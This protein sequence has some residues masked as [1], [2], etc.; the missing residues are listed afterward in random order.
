MHR[1]AVDRYCRLASR[2]A[3]SSVKM[4][5]QM[6]GK[7]TEGPDRAELTKATS[8]AIQQIRRARAMRFAPIAMPTI[9]AAVTPIANAIDVSMN[10]SRVPMP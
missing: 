8:P 3:A 1:A 10:S 5:T 4:L 6:S 7:I 9:G 2:T